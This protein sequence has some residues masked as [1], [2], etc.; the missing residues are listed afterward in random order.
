MEENFEIWWNECTSPDNYWNHWEL[1]EK[2][3]R[4]LKLNPRETH[5]RARLRDLFDSQ[6][7][8]DEAIEFWKSVVQSHTVMAFKTKGNM[9][10]AVKFFEDAKVK[11]LGCASFELQFAY[12]LETTGQT[13]PSSTCQDQKVGLPRNLYLTCSKTMML[14]WQ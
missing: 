10:G 14:A 12:A 5:L 11:Y 6:G 9:N 7:F 2:L 13:W 4:E 1:I 8:I 3:K